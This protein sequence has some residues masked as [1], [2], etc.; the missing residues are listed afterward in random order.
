M[1]TFSWKNK[2]SPERQ[3]LYEVSKIV[4]FIESKSRVV[5]TRTQEGGGN[6]QLLLNMDIFSVKINKLYGFAQQYCTYS[7]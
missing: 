4:K 5:V 1:K 3:V 7:Q 6:E 2:P